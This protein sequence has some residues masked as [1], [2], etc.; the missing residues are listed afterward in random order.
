MNATNTQF[1]FA[2]ATLKPILSVPRGEGF[3]QAVEE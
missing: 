3:E 2:R 1:S